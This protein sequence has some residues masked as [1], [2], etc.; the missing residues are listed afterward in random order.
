MVE[1]LNVLIKLDKL[2]DK[3]RIGYI[4]IGSLAGCLLGVSAIEPDDIDILV[5][6]E[7]I[8]KLNTM[9]QQEQ[10]IDML[11]PVRW[12]EESTIKGLYG[13]A[14]LDGVL[15]DIMADVQ[16]KYLDKWMLFIYE[17]LLHAQ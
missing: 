9:I 11:E 5:S 1:L 15:V 13:R 17:K 4:V 10:G 7:N 14:L 6:K 8:E 2:L 16:L 3:C 12:R